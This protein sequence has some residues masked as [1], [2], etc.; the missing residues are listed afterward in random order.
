VYIDEQVSDGLYKCAWRKTWGYAASYQDLFWWSFRVTEPAWLSRVDIFS[1]LV[2]PLLPV[3]VGADGYFCI[4]S[5]SRTH[6]HTHARARDRTPLEEGSTQRS[7]LYLTTHNTPKRLT[8]MPPAGF[9]PALPAGERPQ[10]H[11]LDRAATGIGQ[12]KHNSQSCNYDHFCRTSNPG[13]EIN[14]GMDISRLWIILA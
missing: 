5:H 13:L 2:R 6:T 7:D 9:E 11:S 1:V 8:S 3:L 4:R 10:T 14:T 12:F